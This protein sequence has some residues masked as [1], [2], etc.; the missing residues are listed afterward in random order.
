MSW[1]NYSQGCL[2]G[3]CRSTLKY[4]ACINASTRDAWVSNCW[5]GKSFVC[6]GLSLECTYYDTFTGSAANDVFN[7][8]N[9]TFSGGT[10]VAGGGN[11]GPD[12]SGGPDNGGVTR[13]P[14]P[15][16]VVIIPED[17]LADVTVHLTRGEFES[18]AQPY[19][20]RTTAL[21][22]RVLSEAGVRPDELGG[23]LLSWAVPNGPSLN[24][25]DK[26]LAV[27]TEDHPLDYGDFEGTI[28]AGEY[29]GGSVMLWDE[30][31]WA[32]VPGK[33]ADDLS[34]V[35]A[36]FFD[37]GNLLLRLDTRATAIDRAART[38]TTAAASSRLPA[39]SA[40]ASAFSQPA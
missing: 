33:S 27:R 16:N 6:K 23:V 38:V 14:T 20:D 39:R 9:L 18:S 22:S 19:L 11:G 29:G 32:P 35:P 26:R 24:P 2:I 3:I 10:I 7:Y 8:G 5:R 36:G 17:P 34:L 28:P 30:G 21:T 25:R 4:D 15:S 13:T 40:L 12:A 31:T 1:V 37:R